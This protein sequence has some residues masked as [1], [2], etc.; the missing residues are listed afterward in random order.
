MK[1]ESVEVVILNPEGKFIFLNLEEIV[2]FNNNFTV[3]L[4]IDSNKVFV[5]NNSQRNTHF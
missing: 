5:F 3:N 2:Q 4:I 1:I